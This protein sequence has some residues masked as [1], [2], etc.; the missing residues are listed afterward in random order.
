MIGLQ[1]FINGLQVLLIVGDGGVI[2]LKEHA[3]FAQFNGCLHGASTRNT[4]N[5]P[6]RTLKS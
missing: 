5:T 4:K 3:L 6:A 2:Q 1:N